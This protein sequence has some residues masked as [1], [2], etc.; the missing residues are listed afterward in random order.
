MANLL[1]IFFLLKIL[2]QALKS[3]QT[4]LINQGTVFDHKV[5]LMKEL[6][7]QKKLIVKDQ[8]NLQKGNPSLLRNNSRDFIVDQYENQK[9]VKDTERMKRAAFLNRSVMKF[10][11]MFY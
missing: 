7:E 3:P 9:T 8:L 4:A 1:K 5:Q 6:F 10:N 2:L 11:S